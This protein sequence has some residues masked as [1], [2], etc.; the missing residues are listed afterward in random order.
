MLGA[1][2]NAVG[3]AE[4]MRNLNMK[5]MMLGAMALGLPLGLA[6]CTTT[7]PY[8]GEQRV[9]RTTQGA[10]GGAALGAIIGAVA[11]D[12]EAALAGAAAGALIGGGIGQYMDRQEAELRRE[13]ASTGVRVQRNGDNIRLIMPG[14]ITFATN[15][16]AVRPEFYA[17][18]N[19]VSRVLERYDQTNVLVEGHTDNVGSDQYNLNLSIRRAESVGN[20]LAAQGVTI[21]RIRALGYGETQPIEANSTDQG[22][23]QNRRVEIQLTPIQG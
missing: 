4:R 20:Y 18:L 14:N 16:S 21:P 1:Y 10:L 11:G 13:L 23:A 12:D 19:S 8:T 9:S 2:P 22:R 17:T 7:D 5:K 15:Q 3:A 6:A